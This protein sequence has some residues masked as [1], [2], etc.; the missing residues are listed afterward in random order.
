[1]CHISPSETLPSWG[2]CSLSFFQISR[3]QA[4]LMERTKQICCWKHHHRLRRVP[5]WGRNQEPSLDLCPSNCDASGKY[6]SAGMLIVVACSVKLLW[7]CENCENAKMSLKI[8]VTLELRGSY[9]LHNTKPQNFM[10]KSPLQ[11]HNFS[12]R[13]NKSHDGSISSLQ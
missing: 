11:A 8:S 3:I 9:F 2:T 5:V 1:M 7:A 4:E 10:A 13:F 6:P 12:L